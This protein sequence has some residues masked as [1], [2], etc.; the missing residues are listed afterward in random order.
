MV[1]TGVPALVAAQSDRIAAAELERDGRGQ[2]RAPYY[3]SWDGG[4]YAP[5]YS[6]LSR[7]NLSTGQHVF[8]VRARDA[9]NNTDE[10]AATWTWTI[11]TKA[12][13]AQEIKEAVKDLE[14]SRS[15]TVTV[16]AAWAVL[17]ETSV[18]AQV[19]VDVPSGMTAKKRAELTTR[20]IGRRED[21]LIR[22]A[23]RG[24]A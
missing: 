17:L 22:P 6:P 10:S 16:N 24:G 15:S 2:G 8:G 23:A 20:R 4:P 14:L 12:Q 19:T 9:W 5:C 11:L 13:A 1:V 18:A 21:Q 3:C 7:S